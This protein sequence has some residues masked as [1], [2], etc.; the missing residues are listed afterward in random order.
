MKRR[1]PDPYCFKIR[2]QIY[3]QIKTALHAAQDESSI[4]GQLFIV[5]SNEAINNCI[6]RSS[7]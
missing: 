3:Y 1:R 2:G 6:N 4:Y 7:C 5:D